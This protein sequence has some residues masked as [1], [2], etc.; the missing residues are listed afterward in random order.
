MLEALRHSKNRRA[1]KN[2]AKLITKLDSSQHF[3]MAISVFGKEV[4][5]RSVPLLE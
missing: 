4:S 1:R 2:L 3:S 5:S